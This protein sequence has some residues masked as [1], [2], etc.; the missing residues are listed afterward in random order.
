[1]LEIGGQ[2]IKALAQTWRVADPVNR[3]VIRETWPYYFNEYA[4][5]VHYKNLAVEA[6]RMGRN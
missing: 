2:F 3:R 5:A 1:M 4:T 6:D